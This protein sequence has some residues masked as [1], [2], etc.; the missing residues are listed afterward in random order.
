MA[1]PSVHPFDPSS[2]VVAFLECD[3]PRPD[4]PILPVFAEALQKIILNFE[5]I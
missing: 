1:G 4:V 3:E 5:I 2:V